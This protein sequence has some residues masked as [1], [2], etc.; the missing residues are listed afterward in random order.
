MTN[1]EFGHVPLVKVTRGEG[2]ESVHYGAIAVVDSRGALVASVGNPEAATFLRSAAKPFQTLPL[3]VSGAADRL[4]LREKE[5]AVI[6]SSHSGQKMHLDVVRGILRKARLRESALRCGAHAPFHRPTAA[7]LAKGGMRPSVLHNNCSGKHAGMLALARHWRAPLE[8]YL[9]P[10]HPVQKAVLETLCAY[11]G[12]APGSV[13]VGVDGCSAPTFAISL[14]EAAGGYARLLDP[15]FGSGSEREAAR[16]VVDSMR[17]YPEMVGGTNRLDT[18]LMESI[19]RSF[20]AKIGAEGF[21]GMAYRD[22]QRGVGIALKIAD[23]DGDR[24][25]TVA[26]VHLLSRLGLLGKE[27]AAE[28]LE[29]QGLPEVRNVRGSIVGKVS[30]LFDVS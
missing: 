17:G 14:R 13:L 25:R 3:I 21:Y 15:R 11:T 19:G 8:T 5:L 24:A 18:R 20:I 26:T 9:A 7:A 12:V 27:K 28:I 10:D 23:G 22:G 4:R 6:T 29:S 30:G 1:L 16:R 2:I